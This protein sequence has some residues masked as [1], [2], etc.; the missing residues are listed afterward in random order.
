VPP[1][2]TGAYDRNKVGSPVQADSHGW[3]RKVWVEL[4]AK[5]ILPHRVRRVAHEVPADSS[6]FVKPL[7]RLLCSLKSYEPLCDQWL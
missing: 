5:L 1:K 4:A 2:Q 6:Y 7:T 3:L